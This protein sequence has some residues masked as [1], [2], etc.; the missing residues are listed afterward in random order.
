MTLASVLRHAAPGRLV[1]LGR[2]R[3]GV[4]ALSTIGSMVVRMGSSVILTRLLSPEA[5]GLVGIIG[6]IFFT[7][8]MLTDLGFQSYVVRH[9]RGDERHFRDVI[10]TIHAWRGLALALLAAAASPLIA[11]FM[12]KPELAWPIAVVGST[13][14]LNGVASLS[15]MTALRSDS[16]RLLSVLDLLFQIFQ[17]LSCLLLAVWLRSVWAII[18]SM[19]LQSAVR[20]VA[21]YFIFPDAGHRL[22]RDRDV[23]RDFFAFSRIVLVSS[24]LSLLLFQS[25]KLVLGRLL[26][27]Q[28]FGLYAIA[29]NL[30]SAPASFADSYISRVSFPLYASTWRTDPGRLSEVYYSVGRMPSLLYALVC[31]GLAGGAPLGIAI[32]YDDR[33][34]GAGPFLSLLAIG[35]ALR[36]PNFAA[37]EVQTAIGRVKG[38][39]HANIVR[40]AWLAVAGTAG[41]RLY[42]PIGLVGAV[43]LMELPALAYNWTALQRLGILNLRKEL[44][45]VACALAGAAIAFAASRTILALMPSL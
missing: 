7:L 38:T 26:T 24:A 1:A 3:S 32:L 27:L 37:A 12:Q 20:S 9:E 8:G 28:E 2:T 13:F 31:G 11:D 25:D 18:I 30:S 14:F 33:Y 21:S 16:A 40:I 39:M 42:G 34:A 5:F 10:W 35:S 23:S 17:T 43:G 36:F 44:V 19:V 6:S 22:A 15:Q 4:L 29:L 45:F 41:F